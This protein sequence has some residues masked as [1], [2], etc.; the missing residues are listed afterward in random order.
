V[1]ARMVPRI[2][3]L[4]FRASVAESYAL[5]PPVYPVVQR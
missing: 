4:H 5:L 1:T 2:T 3:G